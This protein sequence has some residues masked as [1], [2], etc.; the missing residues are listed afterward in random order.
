MASGICPV[1]ANRSARD[2]VGQGRHPLSGGGLG[3]TDAVAG[4][5]DD[6]G[7]V[8]APV[9]GGVG[10]PVAFRFPLHGV[11][12]LVA[13]QVPCALGVGDQALTTGHG[14]GLTPPQPRWG[15]VK[16]RRCSRSRISVA[17]D[18]ALGQR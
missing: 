6:V 17:L 5:H 18:G 3:Q 2:S 4:G 10:E 8:Q 15:R 11:A 13:P 14:M 7:V 9:D 1:V 12:A 16:S